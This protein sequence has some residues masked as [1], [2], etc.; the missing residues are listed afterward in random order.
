MPAAVE[1]SIAG[2]G[3]VKL[4]GEAEAVTVVIR[5]SGDYAGQNLKCKKAEATVTGSGDIALG[6][7]EEVEATTTGS[8]DITYL[9]TPAR[10]HQTHHRLGISAREITPPPRPFSCLLPFAFC[11]PSA[12]FAAL[13]RPLPSRLLPASGGPRLFASSILQSV[14]HHFGGPPSR[15]RAFSSNRRSL[16]ASGSISTAF[17]SASSASSN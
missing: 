6:L 9:G 5:G 10:V 11:A 7:V 4:A 3:N 1:T 14:R 2:S 17:P 13:R 12:P 15:R 16:F 8:G